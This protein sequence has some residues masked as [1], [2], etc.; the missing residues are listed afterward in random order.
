[1]RCMHYSLIQGD[2]QKCEGKAHDK[3]EETEVV[4][5]LPD[6]WDRYEELEEDEIDIP[7][8]RGEDFNKLIAESGKYKL[9]ILLA[10]CFFLPQGY[11]VRTVWYRVNPL[12]LSHQFNPLPDNHDL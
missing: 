7:E 2:T 3:E 8:V 11:K 4:R 5:K 12:P 10:R 1:M 6:N 9:K